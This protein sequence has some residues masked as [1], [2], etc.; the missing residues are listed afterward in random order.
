MTVFILEDALYG[1]M[2]LGKR[3]TTGGSSS[4][5]IMRLSVPVLTLE[6]QN[7]TNNKCLPKFVQ[8]DNASSSIKT[9]NTLSNIIKILIPGGQEFL[10]ESVDVSVFI[11]KERI[12]PLLLSTV[13]SR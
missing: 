6:R 13:A 9:A 10:L 7:Q 8:M 11:Q 1:W 2:N 3:R 12:M 4:R 5:R